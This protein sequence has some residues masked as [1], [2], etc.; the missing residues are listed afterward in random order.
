MQQSQCETL[1]LNS[2]LEI[3]NGINYILTHIAG[4][5]LKNREKAVNNSSIYQQF[6]IGK[7]TLFRIP[8]GY[9]F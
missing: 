2:K 6:R 1:I 7:N 9:K 5:M 8:M 4:Q 3:R